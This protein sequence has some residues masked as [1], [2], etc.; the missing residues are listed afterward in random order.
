MKIAYCLNSIS[1]TGGIE[2]ITVIKANALAAINGNE[3]YIIV[4]DHKQGSG[5]SVHLSP[6]VHFVD[7]DV[8]YYADDWKSRWYVWKGIFIKRRLHKKRLAAVLHAIQPNVVISLGQAEKYLL[9][10][11]RGNWI[12]I[13]ELHFR[14]DFRWLAARSWMDKIAAILSNLYEYGYKITQYDHIVTLTQEDR[15]CNWKRQSQLSVI[16]NLLTFDR[17]M[18]S[19]LTRKKV[20]TIG[21]LSEEKNFASLIRA[22]RMVVDRHSDW[23]LEIYGDGAQKDA[24][25]TLINRLSLY[26]HVFLMGQTDQVQARLSEASCFVLTSIYEGLPLVMLEALSCGL[27]IVSYDCPCG[28][29]DI[30]TDGI[31]G[32]LVPAGDEQLLAN[33]ICYLIEN[34]DKRAEMGTAALKKSKY[35]EPEKIVPMWMD[36]FERLLQEKQNKC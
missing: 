21:R 4:T 36:L 20:I 19:A 33:K 24:L 32:F 1:H 12:K 29:K 18:I 16:P 5:P 22:F 25:Q 10:E 31:D 35:Y 13:R 11:I 8:D 17:S 6:L 27:P 14:K 26:E 30:I 23:K 28:P 2:Q 7:L 3:V 34:P 9:T 15:D